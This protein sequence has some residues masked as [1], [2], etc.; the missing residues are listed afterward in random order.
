MRRRIG[1]RT[2]GRDTRC[3]ATRPQRALQLACGR[4]AEVAEKLLIHADQAFKQLADNPRI[5]PMAGSRLEILSEVRKWRMPGFPKIIIFYEPRSNGVSIVRILHAA[6][7]W[8]SIF[9]VG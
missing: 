3:C 9:D 5:G 2:R 4:G 6:Q 1:E 8:W 7:D